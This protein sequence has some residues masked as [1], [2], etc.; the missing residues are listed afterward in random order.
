MNDDFRK[1]YKIESDASKLFLKT[2]VNVNKK[3]GVQ[4][5]FR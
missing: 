5:L 3:Q 2:K 1:L 4:T